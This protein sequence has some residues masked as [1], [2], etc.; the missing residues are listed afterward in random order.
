MHASLDMQPNVGK[1]DTYLSATALVQL[2]TH[3][4]SGL[5]SQIFSLHLERDHAEPSIF[6]VLVRTDPVSMPQSLQH[7]CASQAFTEGSHH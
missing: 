5:L 4:K 6:P 7:M 2:R 3:E 1:A